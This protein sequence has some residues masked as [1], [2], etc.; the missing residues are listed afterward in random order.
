ME[1]IRDQCLAAG[2][3]VPQSITEGLTNVALMEAMVGQDGVGGMMTMLG[4]AITSS[5]EALQAL[6]NS[7][8]FGATI[9]QE[10]A[11]AIAMYSGY[12]YDANTGIWTQLSSDSSVAAQQVAD[13]LNAHGQNMDEQLAQGLADQYGVV[14]ENGKWVVS[15]AAEGVRDNTGEFVGASEDMAESGTSAMNDITSS[16]VLDAPTVAQPDMTT[17]VSNA[18]WNAQSWLNNN[19]LSVA[20]NAIGNFV[21]GLFGYAKGGIVEEPQVAMVGEAGDE[22]IIP[23]ENNRARALDLWHEAGERLNA[24]AADQ[25]R[26][27]GETMRDRIIQQSTD[28]SRTITVEEGAITIHTQTVDG[29]KIYREITQEMQ[30]EVKRK[31]VAY[32]SI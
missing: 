4:M 22:A 32:G 21:G 19:P 2:E 10:L 16:T 11:S 18:R 26:S 20:V 14:Y 6:Q 23:L 24:F 3:T 29:K 7:E 15:K 30:R 27:T 17:P 13:E 5:P 25:G 8:M 31:E 9:P 1:S 28:N 12:V